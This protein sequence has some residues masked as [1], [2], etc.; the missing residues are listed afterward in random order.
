MNPKRYSDENK[1][2]SSTDFE[3]SAPKG[4][5]KNPKNQPFGEHSGFSDF[6][7]DDGSFKE[8]KKVPT[9]N[10]NK[11]KGSDNDR[12]FTP[13]EMVSCMNEFFIIK[14]NKI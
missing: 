3:R 6:V 14:N 1:I 2:D 5:K 7:L 13:S 8:S 9:S 12:S 11:S 10:T 4:N